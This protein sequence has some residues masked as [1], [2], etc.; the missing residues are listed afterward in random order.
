VN[1]LEASLQAAR[2]HLLQLRRVF[3]HWRTVALGS[4][5]ERNRKWQATACPARCP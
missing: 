3:L 4:K 1:R 2:P 5:A